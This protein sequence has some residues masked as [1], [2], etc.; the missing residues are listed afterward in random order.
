MPAGHLC[1]LSAPHTPESPAS[2]EYNYVSVDDSLSRAHL[3]P[4]LFTASSPI[5]LQGYIWEDRKAKAC[6]TSLEEKGKQKAE[7]QL[8]A[9]FPNDNMKFSHSIQF[10]AVPDWSSHYIAYSNLKKL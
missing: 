7:H 6:A 10:N 8:Q 9:P 5:E 3:S 2:T 1:T 4:I